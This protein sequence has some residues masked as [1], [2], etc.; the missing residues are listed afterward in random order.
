MIQATY[1]REYNRLTIRGHAHS[2][3]PGHDLV[4]SAASI[5]AYTLAA[6]LMQLEEQ[7]IL[8]TM[9]VNLS[10]GDAEISCQSST[11]FRSTVTMI[12]DAVCLGFDLLARD[13]PEYIQWERLGR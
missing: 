12:M 3:E 8:H 9:S 6:N 13:F 10:S 5:L 2:G 11:R 7:G 1:H 4:C